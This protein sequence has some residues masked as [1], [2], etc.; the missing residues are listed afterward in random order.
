MRRARTLRLKLRDI[1]RRCQDSKKQ[2]NNQFMKSSQALR[3]EQKETFSVTENLK[4]M[5]NTFNKLTRIKSKNS[6]MT[7]ILVF[8]VI[9]S[10]KNT[11]VFL[12]IPCSRNIKLWRINTIKQ[13]HQTF[14]TP[15]GM[16]KRYSLLK[17][18]QSTYRERIKQYEQK[19]LEL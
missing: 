2:G 19:L 17:E 10:C 12:W 1:K 4:N 8:F 7:Y 11:I 13:L 3:K 16:V 5:C 9:S 14:T 15:E 18:E 6:S